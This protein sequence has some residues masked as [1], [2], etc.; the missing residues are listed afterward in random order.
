VVSS[1]D[2]NSVRF[3]TGLEVVRAYAESDTLATDVEVEDTIGA[4]LRYEN[5]A[6]GVIQ[7]GSSMRG[8]DYQTKDGPRIFGT[9]G[10]I[11]LNSSGR[12]EKPIIYLTEATEGSIPGK[13]HDLEFSGKSAD[14][15]SIVEGFAKA[16]LSGVQPPTSGTDGRKALE[17]VLACY[18]SAQ[19]KQAIQLPI[20]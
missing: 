14:R 19:E 6:I 13:W 17:V 1:H 20:K 3:V 18:R 2:L 12:M 10:Q 4:V 16:V 11:I 8:G 7:A 9:K 15:Q 5:G